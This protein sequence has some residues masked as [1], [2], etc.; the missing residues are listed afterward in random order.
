MGRRTPILGVI[1]LH[2]GSQWPVLGKALAQS[3]SAFAFGG[4][5][6][7]SQCSYTSHLGATLL[8]LYYRRVWL[9]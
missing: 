4:M 8:L 3:D 7:N 6:Q 2:H 9:Q 1:I 5:A